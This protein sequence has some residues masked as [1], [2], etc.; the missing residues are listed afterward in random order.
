MILPQISQS[1]NIRT[2]VETPG[3]WV[4]EVL[5]SPHQEI[6]AWLCQLVQPVDDCVCKVTDICDLKV[7]FSDFLESSAYQFYRAR[8]SL[9]ASSSSLPIER[10][11][12]Q[13][14]LN[15][16]LLSAWSIQQWTWEIN[17]SFISLLNLLYLF[18]YFWLCWV[19]IAVESGG[20]SFLRCAGFL[21]R[22][23]LLLWS[24]GSRHV[25][26]SSCG[27]QALERRLSSC[28]SWA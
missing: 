16:R 13:Q 26:F 11:F 24:T 9:P 22:W 17:C 4:L 10:W 21:L 12:I 25:G 1:V 27:T 14:I 6:N 3:L 23:L 19:F 8:G 2:R 28:G 7:Q 18:I 5:F 20:Y 15:E